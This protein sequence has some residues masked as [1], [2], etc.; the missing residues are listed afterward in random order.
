MCWCVI[1][2]RAGREPAA[3]DLLQRTLQLKVYLPEVLQ[4]RQGKTQPGPLFPGYLFVRDDP[5]SSALAQ[6]DS[7]PGCG[8]LLRLG[9][10]HTPAAERVCVTEEVVQ[11]LQAKVARLN[12]AG[13]LPAHNL[14][15]GDT[16]Q[17]TGGLMRG[18]SAVF[19]GPLTPAARIQVLLQFLGRE[20]T[21][22]V[23][24]ES[25]EPCAPAWK[26]PRR[27]RGHGRAVHAA[28]HGARAGS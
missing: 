20:Q 5:A 17:I 3:A 24:A 13:G 6:V 21:L 26:R 27:T 12:Q 8:H 18:L 9:R 1:H 11:L 2:V 15:P 10:R 7:T 28:D 19:V 4:R 23:A 25:V 14:H 16:V 22:T